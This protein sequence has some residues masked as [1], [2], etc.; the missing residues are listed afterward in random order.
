MSQKKLLLLPKKTYEILREAVS[1]VHILKIDRCECSPEKNFDDFF[2]EY[3]PNIELDKNPSERPVHATC[4]RVA[5]VANYFVTINPKSSV[6][7]DEFK[8]KV[9]RYIQR[10]MITNATYAFEQRGTTN[11]DIGKGL[12]CHMLIETACKDFKRNTVSTFKPLVGKTAPLQKVVN[13]KLLRE[14]QW[15]EDKLEHLKGNKYGLDKDKK[16]SGDE[17]FRHKNNLNVLYTKN[18]L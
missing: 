9:E 8:A 12:H 11:A 7:L 3:C 17:L 4:R 13:I 15:I 1:N 10:S 18:A 16:V 5:N 6:Q 2:K 14:P